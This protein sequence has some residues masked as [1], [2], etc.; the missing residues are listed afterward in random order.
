MIQQGYISPKLLLYTGLI[1]GLVAIV[2]C[3]SSGMLAGVAVIMVLPVAIYYLVQIIRFPIIAFYGLLILNYFIIA[4]MRYTHTSGLSVI[5][6]I[7]LFSIIFAAVAHSILTRKLP[8]GNAFN[9]LTMASLIWAIYCSFELLNPTAISEA[10]TSS[11]GIIYN[12][13]IVSLI[14]SILISQYKYVKQLLFLLSILVL[15][16]VFKALTQ[17]YI[18]FDAVE[19]QWLSEG[20]A[21]T[22]IIATGTRYFS[23]FTD[24]GNFGSNMGFASVVF[25]ISAIYT[26]EKKKRIY[27]IT[28]A[29]LALYSLFLSGTRGALGVPLGGL[30]LFCL[31]NKRI[32]LMLITAFIGLFIYIF[33]AHTYIGQGNSMIRRMR[34]TFRPTEDASFNVRL[35]NQKKL[36]EYL[37]NRPFGEG[38]GLGGVEAQR[39]DERFTTLIPHDST[40]VKIWMETGI[41]G[42][43][44]YLG[45]LVITLLWACYIVMFRVKHNK[46]RGMLTAMICGVF[47]LMISA[48]GN[49]FFN[50]FPTQ[51]IVFT[52]LTI[53]LN[54]HRIE[55]YTTEIQQNKQLSAI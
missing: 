17:R 39:F 27:Y 4:I 28:V 22:H 55:K 35:E 23:F 29:L 10:W 16:A 47:G 18:G 44:L 30:L 43:T 8:W 15:L 9:F 54:G 20:G 34:T 12:G 31:I 5:M 11:R 53:A 1:I 19:R 32:S 52:C 2:I 25:G 49:A 6:D 26:S 33:F 42:L 3:A 14:A 51:I 41:V 36:A 45:M 21:L 48:Y 7:G 37:K 40:Y 13:V 46:L 24:A 50:Q 38:L